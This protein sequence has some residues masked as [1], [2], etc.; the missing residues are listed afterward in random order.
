M[1]PSDAVEWRLFPVWVV[2]RSLSTRGPLDALLELPTG[3][4]RST[5]WSLLPLIRRDPFPWA[6]LR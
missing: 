3:E 1:L 4:A 6:I 2:I 5:W